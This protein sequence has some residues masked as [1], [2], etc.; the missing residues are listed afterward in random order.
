MDILL[1]SQRIE[2]KITAFSRKIGLPDDARPRVAAGEDA[3]P[4]ISQL[5]QEL[6]DMTNLYEESLRVREHEMELL[7]SR[8]AEAG[9]HTRELEKLHSVN[10]TAE[11]EVQIKKQE[12]TR[13][14]SRI[15]ELKKENALLESD[16][17]R[18]SSQLRI[19]WQSTPV[20]GI[21]RHRHGIGSR[22]KKWLCH[23]MI[24]ARGASH[25]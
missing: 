25:E 1:L 23:P 18:M 7:K 13:L 20:N 4:E 15:D 6:G 12:I 19:A 8:L 14:F 24:T 21:R 3:R 17:R 10:V 5:K 16:T 2:Q 22:I 9:Y 11:H